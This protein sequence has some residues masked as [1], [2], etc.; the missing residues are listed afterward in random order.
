VRL[1]TGFHQLRNGDS[2]ATDPL[3]EVCKGVSGGHNHN[4]T[5]GRLFELGCASDGGRQQKCEREQ[6]NRY[7]N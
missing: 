6:E 3:C 1:N 4:F 5:T 7:W 2:L